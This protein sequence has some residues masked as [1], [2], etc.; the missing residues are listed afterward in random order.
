MGFLR[1]YRVE[2]L[3]SYEVGLRG[4]IA[5]LGRGYNRTGSEWL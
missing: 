5:V 3:R 4:L 1:I 2:L